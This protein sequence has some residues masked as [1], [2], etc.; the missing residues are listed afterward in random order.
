MRD[1]DTIDDYGSDSL[2]WAERLEAL[3]GAANRGR[4]VPVV[5]TIVTRLSEGR[6]DSAATIV[7]A[8]WDTIR[9]YP[10]IVYVLK[11]YGLAPAWWV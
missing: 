3:E 10:E 9:T 8:N 4:G 6:I 7:E 5:R 2:L 1:E 11:L